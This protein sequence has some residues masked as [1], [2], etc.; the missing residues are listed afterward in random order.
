V[1][2]E[3]VPAL[4]TRELGRSG[5]YTARMMALFEGYHGAH[6]THGNMSQ[7]SSKGG[8]MEIKGTARTVREPVTEQLWQDHIDG[9][10]PLGIIPIRE[11]SM[12]LWGC[13]DVD[14]Y[15]ISHAQVVAEI[16]KRS[17]PLVVCRT[18]SGGVHAFLFL[19]HPTPAADL[20]D[21]LREISAVMG[22]GDSEVFPKQVE[23][24]SDKGDLGNWLNM[25]YLGGDQTT[26]YCV[27][28]NGNGMSL[29]EFIGFAESKRTTLDEVSVDTTPQDETLNDGPPCLQHLS[30]VGFPEGTRNNGLFSLGIFCKKKFGER[31]REMLDKYN[32]DFMRPPLPTEEVQAVIKALEKKDYQYKCK[33]QPIVDY[34]NSALCKQRK[35]GIGGAGRYPSIVSM[36]K[37]DAGEQTLWFVDVDDRRIELTTTQLLNYRE[38]QRVCMEQ[39]T[40]GF[41]PMRSDTWMEMVG[42]A[43]SSAT[44]IEPA[45]ELTSK[46]HFLELLEE[47]LTNRHR[48]SSKAEIAMGKPW[49]DEEHGRYYFR[50]RDLM[51]FLDR[52]KFDEWGRNKIARVIEDELGGRDF[53]NIDGRGVNVFWVDQEHVESPIIPD[54]PPTEETPV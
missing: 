36:S 25:P 45:I 48:A 19:S 3:A 38:F 13:I 39:L 20:R 15:D 14:K 46:G 11:D 37:L 34:C 4:G 5:D 47:M 23:I 2:P 49:L 44:I 42:G 33:D 31:W 21:T 41:M 26:R 18:K 28:P 16:Q 17:L 1:E 54:S 35:F 40:I 10:R 27:K 24:L 9:V 43:M 8:K 30:R 12:C 29:S 7:S 52:R 50:L 22:W 51:D 6:G 32:R 53:L